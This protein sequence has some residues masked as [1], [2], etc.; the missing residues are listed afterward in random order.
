MLLLSL[1]WVAVAFGDVWLSQNAYIY[2]RRDLLCLLANSSLCVAL[3]SAGL[4]V[5]CNTW[6]VQSAKLCGLLKFLCVIQINFKV[7]LIWIYLWDNIL[8]IV[9]YVIGVFWKMWGVV[10]FEYIVWLGRELWAA[11]CV[12]CKILFIYIDILRGLILYRKNFEQSPFSISNLFALE[13]CRAFNFSYILSVLQRKVLNWFC[14]LLSF[15]DCP[16]AEIFEK[17]SLSERKEIRVRLSS[18]RSSSKPA[19]RAGIF[20]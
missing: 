6:F 5:Q 8:I 19:F 17:A 18:G 7:I 15:W 14:Q 1:Y 4:L 16:Y 11:L 10:V 3:Q 9:K 12:C 13:K 20:N 2:Q